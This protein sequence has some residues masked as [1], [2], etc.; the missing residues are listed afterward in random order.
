MTGFG[1]P[2]S[3]AVPFGHTL[4]FGEA[5]HCV[6]VNSFIK[7]A[8]PDW[9]PGV[10]ARIRRL[11]LAFKEL[12]QYMEELVLTKQLGEETTIREGS[13]FSNLVNSSTR[14]ESGPFHLEDDEI[15][16]KCLTSTMAFC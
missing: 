12:K 14:E 9:I 13:L 10:T 6:A 1:V 16:G 3:E 15:F 8:I 2:L 5:L 4:S 11:R 7:L